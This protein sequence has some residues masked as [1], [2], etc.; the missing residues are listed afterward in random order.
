[1]TIPARSAITWEKQGK[2]WSYWDIT[3]VAWNVDLSS[4][5][6]TTLATQPEKVIQ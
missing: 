5:L 6:T 2:P 3:G 1:M 4:V